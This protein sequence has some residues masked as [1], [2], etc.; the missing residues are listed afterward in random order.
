MLGAMDAARRR[1]RPRRRVH[2]CP[3]M[4][5]TANRLPIDQKRDRVLRLGNTVVRLASGDP[6]G[7]AR[8]D[9]RGIRLVGEHPAAYIDVVAG[10]VV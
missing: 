3:F 9:A 5:R 10:E 8:Y 7:R 1:G 2:C 6:G 4:F